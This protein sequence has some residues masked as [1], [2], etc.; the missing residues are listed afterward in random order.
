MTRLEY[1]PK[2]LADIEAYYGIPSE[3]DFRETHM[4]SL[5]LP[6]AL[7]ASW[8]E[9][10]L[11][12]GLLMHKKVVVAMEDALEEILEL[13]GEEKL[14]ELKWNYLGD[15]LAFR[16]KKA[17]KELSTHA[18]GIALDLNPALGPFGKPCKKYP[19]VIVD[20]FERRGFIWGGRWAR[21]DAMHFQAAKG[22]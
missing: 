2:G 20:A 18:W 8:D 5:K 10:K 7:V 21:Q 9:A 3:E 6:F 14:I 15:A 1:V 22:F 12:R 4:V 11:I 17:G 13:V 19:K 16:K